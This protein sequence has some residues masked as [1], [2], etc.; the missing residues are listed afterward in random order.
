MVLGP[1]VE[2]DPPPD[3]LA[4]YMAMSAWRSRPLASWLSGGH[5]RPRG[6]PSRRAGGPRPRG[7]G[8]SG[9]RLGLPLRR[10]SR[11]R[12]HR[13]A[14]PRTRPPRG[15]RPGCLGAERAE[16]LGDGLEDGVTGVV[17]EG[18]VDFLKPSRSISITA[19]RPSVGDC[20]R[21]SASC[22]TNNARLGRPVKASCW[23]WY[24]RTAA[25]WRSCS[26]SLLL[27]RADARIGGEGLEEPQV[28]AVEALVAE[29]PVGDQQ[30][31]GAGV[32]LLQ[33]G[34][35]ASFSPRSAMA[36]TTIVFRLGRPRT[37]APPAR[38]R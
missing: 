3:P 23:A 9:P 22:S 24:W 27:R 36:M 20:P 2:V 25:S 14:A 4:V 10:W 38:R 32:A 5:G 19:T 7:A 31:P 17:A 18:V 33:R 6:S 15:G 37:S 1:V 11:L 34:A 26:S 30:V 35:M 8:R 16:P 28:G 29:G 21:A 13:A 12:A